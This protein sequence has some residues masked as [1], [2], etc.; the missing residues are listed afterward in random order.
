MVALVGKA[1]GAFHPKTLMGVKRVL[2]GSKY[3]GGTNCFNTTGRV[4][5]HWATRYLSELH[6]T[7]LLPIFQVLHISKQEYHCIWVLTLCFPQWIAIEF[8]CYN[9]LRLVL[10]CGMIWSLEAFKVSPSQ[11]S[12]VINCESRSKYRDSIIRIMITKGWIYHDI[13]L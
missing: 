13:A 9:C 7:L 3:F 10:L 5:C 2:K 12:K 4:V 8:S 1:L 11:V 6:H